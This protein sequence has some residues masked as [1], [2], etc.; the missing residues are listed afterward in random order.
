[1]FH[2]AISAVYNTKLSVPSH[3]PF[4]RLDKAGDTQWSNALLLNVYWTKLI[5]IFH[6]SSAL[7]R[8]LTF[9]V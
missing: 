1:M 6:V 8:H 4:S 9:Q 3:A 2:L 7:L 5:Q